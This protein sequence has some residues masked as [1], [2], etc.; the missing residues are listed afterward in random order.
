MD[1][2]R[3]LV[4]PAK[5]RKSG[6]NAKGKDKKMLCLVAQHL[7]ESVIQNLVIQHLHNQDSV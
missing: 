3:V 1:V 7:L 2:H 4:C 5:V 6:G